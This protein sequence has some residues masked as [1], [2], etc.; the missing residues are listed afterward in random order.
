MA[1]N[2]RPFKELIAMTKEKLE[3]SMIPLRVRAAKA[4]AEGIQVELETKQLD[5]ESRINAACAEKD[6]NFTRIADMMDEYELNE[7]RLTQI[8]NLV[9]QLFPSES[10]LRGSP[11]GG[12]GGTDDGVK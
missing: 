6:I 1:F 5:L 7:R 3:E 8:N 10:G 2:I 9:M 12:I 11:A 4:K